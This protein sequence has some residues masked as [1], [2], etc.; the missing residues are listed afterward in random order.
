MQN[1]K[2]YSEVKKNFTARVE[3]P[4]TISASLFQMRWKIVIP[5][6]GINFQKIEHGYVG[7][8]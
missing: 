1:T 7:A 2:I 3:N 5:F 8:L 6:D 4:V